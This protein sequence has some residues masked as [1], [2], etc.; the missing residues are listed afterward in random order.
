M[1]KDVWKICSI[2]WNSIIHPNQRKPRSKQVCSLRWDSRR[3]AFNCTHRRTTKWGT[4]QLPRGWEAPQKPRSGCR[5]SALMMSSPCCL[6]SQSVRDGHYGPDAE[7]EREKHSQ[8]CYI[9]LAKPSEHVTPHS[10]PI[11]LT[12][13]RFLN[14][15]SNP[16][17]NIWSPSQHGPLL[18]SPTHSS[19]FCTKMTQIV[20][21]LNVPGSKWGEPVLLLCQLHYERVSLSVLDQLHLFLNSF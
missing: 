14:S 15:A 11:T 7:R 21:F 12:S 18:H 9:L 5:S 10:R 4:L 3:K 2:S 13:S 16:A 8:L 19:I 1:H 20:G 6:R 17:D